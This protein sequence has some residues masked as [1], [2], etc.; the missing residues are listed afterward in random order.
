MVDLYLIIGDI[1]DRFTEEER[2]EL[3]EVIQSVS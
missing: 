2:N 1:E 3:L